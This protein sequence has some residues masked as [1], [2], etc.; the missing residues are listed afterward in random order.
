MTMAIIVLVLFSVYPLKYLFTLVT[1]QLFGLDM[2]NVPHL[3]SFHQVQ[4]LYVI[5]GLGF[6]GVWALYA[7]LY[8]YALARREQLQ[9]DAAETVL[10]R[11]SL[12]EYLIHIGVCALSIVLAL[13]IS[14]SWI[15]G[16]IYGLLGPLQALNGWWFGRRVNALAP[17]AAP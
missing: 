7:V 5:F 13:S 11:A 6:A 8:A 3:E 15:P 16:A 2:H 10:T 12:G 1:V 17:V 4:V 9:L 14:S